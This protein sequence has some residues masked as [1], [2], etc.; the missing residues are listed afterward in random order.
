MR[1][2]V[3]SQVF[4]PDNVSVAQHLSDLCFALAEK[5]H[6]I[7][8]LTSRYAYEEKSQKYN[9]NENINGVFIKRI[10]STGLGKKNV[11]FRIIDFVTFNIAIF[12]SLLFI[13]RKSFDLMIG[14][15]APPLLSFF[16]SL[17]AK[18]KLIKFCYWLMDVQPDLA[19]Q[20]GLIRKDSLAAN[21]L[22]KM[23]DYTFKNS[24]HI[25]VLD[26]FMKEH[27]IERCGNIDN[28]SIIPI[29][30]AMNE[31][32]QGNRFKNPFRIEHHFKNRIVIM[33]SGN[34]S[35]VHPLDTILELSKELIN[36]DRFLFVFIGGGVR[37]KD[38]TEFKNK[39]ELDNIIQ[40]PYQPR[41]KIH[42]SL[43]ASDFQVIILGEG[44]V[45][46]THPNKIYGALFIGKPIIYI[47]PKKSHVTE[48]L[49]SLDNNI[50]IEHGQVSELKLKLLNLAE[51]FSQVEKIGMKNREI[52]LRKYT[53]SLL[54]KQ[55]IYTIE[56]II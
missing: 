4:Y 24:N 31:I 11:I 55:M 16:G 47:G 37:K 1:I 15:T 36:D 21:C 23:S 17:M 8:V 5:G 49:S 52:A 35:Y 13:K 46:Y 29:W 2:I 38:V 41:E 10:W 14:L 50:I 44:Q 25:I 18:R 39:Y 34:H 22:R 6:N 42:L 48:I 19:I 54:V 51:N 27:V 12:C 28:I 40:M 32:F 3:I 30:P 45:G 26:K 56:K 7:F 33:Y 43:G 20:S 53:P 9:Y